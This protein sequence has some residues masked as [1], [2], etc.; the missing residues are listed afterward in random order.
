MLSLSAGLHAVSDVEAIDPVNLTIDISNYKP[1]QVEIQIVDTFWE[2]AVVGEEQ[3][4]CI[5][6]LAPR[7]SF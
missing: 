5:P 6:F 2:L 3:K 7:A 4:P 1:R